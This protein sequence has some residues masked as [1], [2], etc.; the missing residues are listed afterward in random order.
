MPLALVLDAGCIFNPP[1][2]DDTTGSSSGTVTP[3]TDDASATGPT[4][5]PPSDTTT[6]PD[7][8][9]DTTTGPGPDSS[10]GP[11]PGVCG[12]GELAGGEQCDDGGTEDGDGCSDTCQEEL[13]FNCAGEPSVCESS[14]GDGVVASDEACDDGNEDDGDGCTSCSVDSGY[15]CLG[16]MP[17][18]C[19]TLCGD[20]VAVGTEACDDGDVL[21]GNGCAAD[22]TVELYSRCVGEGPGSCAPIRVLYVPADNDD[23]AFR[24]EL[25][26]LTGG[27]ADYIDGGSA[28][29]TLAEL[30]AQYDCVF[31]HPNFS[32][33]DS[34]TLGSTL[35]SFVDGGGNVVLGIAS[36]YPP[37]TGFDGTPIMLAAYSPVTTAAAV[38]FVAV[39]YAG[40]GTSPIHTGVV[41]YGADIADSGVVLQGGGIADATFDNGTISAAYRPDFKV[42]YLNGSGNDS[43]GGTGDWTRLIA[44]ACAAGFL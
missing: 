31:T 11:S 20:G 37:P 9:P 33:Q 38:Q 16:A 41:A 1:A 2:V 22:C 3:A 8:D 17:S 30:Q 39:S 14:C 36:D 34:P 42:V 43:F 44:N 32:Y 21:D 10:S 15:E 5:G 7:P 13:G 28:T 27:T 29:P 4:T 26:A 6:G 18:V 24:A 12:D 40:D 35:A 19:S 23:A 25:V